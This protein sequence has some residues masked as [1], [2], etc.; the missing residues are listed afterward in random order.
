M[1]TNELLTQTE[2]ELIAV[3]AS[4]AAGCQPC[5]VHH[6][7]AARAAGAA[8]QE[9]RQAVDDALCVRNSATK[10]MA[11]WADKHLGCAPHAEAPC[12]SD[13]PL[14]RE[15]VSASAAFALN[16]VTNL[17]SHLAAARRLGASERQ[18]QTALAVA[19]TV[20]KV[21]GQKVE[22]AAEAS[23][24]RADEASEPCGDDCGCHAKRV[25]ESP[26]CGCDEIES[27]A[28]A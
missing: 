26:G 1:S 22:A 27:I 20:K 10:D 16:C 24:V 8:D 13:K 28:T 17:D 12:C 19:R 7:Q 2:K 3:G 4:I 9:I 25:Q 14:I 5:T 11:R 6:F 23:V 21:A 15:L 18:I